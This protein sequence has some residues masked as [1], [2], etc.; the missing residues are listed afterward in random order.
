MCSLPPALKTFQ[1][2]LLREKERELVASCAICLFSLK[3]SP[4]WGLDSV[5]EETLDS[6][7]VTLSSWMCVRDNKS[8]GMSVKVR[9]R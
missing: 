3:I 8:K 1:Y 7:L 2:Y 9:E 5:M 4:D 6:V